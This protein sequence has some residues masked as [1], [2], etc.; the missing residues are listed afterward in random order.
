MLMCRLSEIVGRCCWLIPIML[1]AGC[2]TAPDLETSRRFQ[3]AEKALTA[4]ES[5]DEFVQVAAQYQEILDTGFQSGSVYY[6]Q[7][8]AWLQAGQT[9]R[10]IAA[11]RIAQRALP[12]DLYVAANL[13]QALMQ[14]GHTQPVAGSDS[15][16]DY[17]F[18]WQ[19]AISYA[20]KAWLVTLL[21]IG[22]LLLALAAQLV[23][24]QQELKR[25]NVVVA[26]ILVL[27]ALSLARDWSDI[28]LT[29]HG[30]IVASTLA[31][32]GAAE[33]FEPAFNQS[34]VDGTEFVVLRQQNDWLQIQVGGIGDGWVPIRS[35]VTY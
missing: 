33:S 9:G 4:A 27:A 3:A 24:F 14:S 10:A 34:L 35:C 21:L 26:V 11:Y 23:S 28:E 6:N 13:R 18:F 19:D 12:R 20:E 15:V 31:R 5:A 17:L 2:G 22:V 29:K 32:K 16:W 1:A 30:V 25:L 8:N 7:A